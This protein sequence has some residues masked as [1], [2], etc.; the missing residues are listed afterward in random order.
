MGGEAMNTNGCRYCHR[1]ENEILTPLPHH[2]HDKYGESMLIVYE[3]GDV[4]LWTVEDGGITSIEDFKFNYCP[5]CG[6]D[7]N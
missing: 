3:N 6:R 7:F 5:M 2:K 1:G 4:D